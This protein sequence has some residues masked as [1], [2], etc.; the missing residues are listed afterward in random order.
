MPIP[1][2]SVS[3]NLLESYFDRLWPICRSIMGQGF[4]TSLKILDEI[5]P[6]AKLHFNS[7]TQVF[8]WTIPH[9]WI[10]KEAYFVGPDG[11]RHAEFQQN[12]LHLLNYST[13][14]RGRMG[15]SDLRSHLFSL[16]NM[17]DAIP[18]R[19]SYYERQWGFCL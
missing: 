5:M 7:G 13:G 14:F 16:P 10:P 8:D 6:T 4:R 17:P 1:L 11:R 12:N 3:E 9:E 19:T 18:Y 15:L 2:Q